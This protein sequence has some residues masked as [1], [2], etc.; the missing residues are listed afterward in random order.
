MRT[1]PEKPVAVA[2]DSSSRASAFTLGG[3]V[4]APRA[5]QVVL[6]GL[7]ELRE[8]RLVGERD[9]QAT[10]GE[11]AGEAGETVGGGLRPGDQLGIQTSGLPA[12]L[13][14]G[15][16]PAGRPLRRAHGHPLAHDL[17]GEPAT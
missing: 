16:R 5:V 4:Q 3:S 1:M 6:D 11:A 8:L 7:D 2:S 13:R 15:T 10:A 12:R 14:P 17:A 9:L